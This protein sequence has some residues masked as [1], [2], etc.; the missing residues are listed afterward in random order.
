MKK[1]TLV[2]SVLFFGM[3]ICF[4][5]QIFDNFGKYLAG[6]SSFA[7]S[8]VKKEKEEPLPTFSICSEPAFN[9]NYLENEL[10]VTGSLFYSTSLLSDLGGKNAFPDLTNKGVEYSKLNLE[11]FW[12]KTIL[13]PRYFAVN[14]DMVYEDTMVEKSNK[15]EIRTFEVINSFYYGKCTSVVL[16]RPRKDHELLIIIFGLLSRLDNSPCCYT[17]N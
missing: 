7:E 10:N 14:N 4:S 13:A 5:F 15:S 2:K 9:E 12:N 11:Y 8:K 3:I 17:I 1:L 16:E 6:K